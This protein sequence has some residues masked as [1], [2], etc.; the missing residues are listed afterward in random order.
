MPTTVHIPKNL[1]ARV[2]A[3]AKKLGVSRNRFVVQV[4]QEKLAARRTWPA[5]L[6]RLLETPVPRAVAA[7]VDRMDKAIEEARHDR[8]GPP[9]L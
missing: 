9:E 7:E 1:L 6:V 3:R 2:D 8:A 5:A 4:L